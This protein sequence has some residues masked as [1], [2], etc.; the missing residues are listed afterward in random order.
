MMHG[1]GNLLV[2]GLLHAAMLAPI[3][4]GITWFSRVGVG[5]RHNPISPMRTQANQCVI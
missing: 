5:N 3:G 4:A 1:L 2:V